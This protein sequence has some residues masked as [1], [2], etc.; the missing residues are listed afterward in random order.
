MGWERFGTWHQSSCE[1]PEKISSESLQR[2]N[3][4]L[5]SCQLREKYRFW[6]VPLLREVVH[7]SLIH[8]GCTPKG[9]LLSDSQNNS[10]CSVDKKSLLFEVCTNPQSIPELPCSL[11]CSLQAVPVC[12]VVIY[13]PPKETFSPVC[14]V[15]STCS[16][17]QEAVASSFCGFLCPDTVKTHIFF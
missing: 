10:C 16:F 8:L 3:S 15:R 4:N 13:C 14:R 6:F 12:F 11:S 1:P 7:S 5:F 2:D 17:L 9:Q